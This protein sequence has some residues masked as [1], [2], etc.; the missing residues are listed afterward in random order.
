MKH[1]LIIFSLIFVTNLA[2]S[3]SPK[4]DFI[5]NIDKGISIKYSCKT[6]DKENLY[7]EF[8]KISI[9]KKDFLANLVIIDLNL[10]FV[11]NF[12]KI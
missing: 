8:D 9:L 5:V 7:C 1:L 11:L 10:V 2:I 6:Q 12:L 3:K 4:N